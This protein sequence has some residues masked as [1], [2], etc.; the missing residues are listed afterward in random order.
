MYPPNQFPPGVSFIKKG[1]KIKFHSPSP[2]EWFFDIYPNL[3]EKDRPLECTQNPGEI[4]F[5]PAGWWHMVLNL[6]ISIAVTQNF[7]NKQNLKIACQDILE[8]SSKSQ[9]FILLRNAVCAKDPQL[10][11]LFEGVLLKFEE[12]EKQERIASQFNHWKAVKLICKQH[13]FPLSSTR[14]ELEKAEASENLVYICGEL[15]FK[16]YRNPEENSLQKEL[17]TYKLLIEAKKMSS[18]DKVDFPLVRATGELKLENITW[19]YVVLSRLN[20]DPIVEDYEELGCHDLIPLAQWLGRIL[21]QLHKLPLENST[22]Y[23]LS[24]DPFISFI[25]E[26]RNKCLKNHQ[27][28]GTL[29]YTLLEQIEKY[30]PSENEISNC[31]IRIEKPPIFLH[32]DLTDENIIGKLKEQ[33]IDQYE[34]KLKHQ[35]TNSIAWNPVGIIDFGDSQVG[36]F[37]FELVPLYISCFRCDKKLL[38][39]FLYSYGF[40]KQWNEQFTYC[41]MCYTLLHSCDAMRSVYQWRPE[42]K[43]I[44][45]FQTLAEKLWNLNED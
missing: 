34:Q 4:I 7:V 9:D 39:E 33:D 14:E 31:L 10:D 43:K 20:G 19:P 12:E 11:F 35:C 21:F 8:S 17:E 42:Y 24:W 22:Y 18:L 1:E 44:K 13:N 41:S 40:K 27:K 25:K 45:N 16:F 37:F 28:W 32:G 23:R 5:V 30:L 36:D 15:V 6:E 29:S 38:Q 3:S 2:L 26:Q